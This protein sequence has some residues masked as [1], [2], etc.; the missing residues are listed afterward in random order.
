MA[1]H[2]RAPTADGR[3]QAE[4]EAP[5][6]PYEEGSQ[7]GGGL[8]AEADAEGNEVGATTQLRCLFDI[9]YADVSSARAQHG[10]DHP[11]EPNHRPHLVRVWQPCQRA[12]SVFLRS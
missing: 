12:P 7:L 6:R 4:G 2:R 3:M 11:L 1:R 5:P 8:G 10:R 9:P